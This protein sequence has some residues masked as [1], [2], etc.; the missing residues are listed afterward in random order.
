[1]NVTDAGKKTNRKS[2]E[3]TSNLLRAVSA[4]HNHYWQEWNI[5]L[6]NSSNSLPGVT[7]MTCPVAKSGANLM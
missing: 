6:S 4:T 3:A 2:T 1:M 7:T 5:P